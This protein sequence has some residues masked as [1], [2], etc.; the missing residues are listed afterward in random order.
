MSSLHEITS[1]TLRK[2]QLRCIVKEN[3]GKPITQLSFN[4][5]DMRARNVLATTASD[6]VTIY[7]N[8]HSHDGSD[9]RYLDMMS[10]FVNEKSEHTEGGLLNTITWVKSENVEDED[11]YLVAAGTG[12]KFSV[13]VI[14]QANS[15]VCEMLSGHHTSQVL[16]VASWKGHDGYFI[17]CSANELFVWRISKGGTCVKVAEK[18]LVNVTAA[19]TLEKSST[20]NI[21]GFAIANNKGSI[22]VFRLSLLSFDLL[23]V[24][25]R[26]IFISKNKRKTQIDCV[27]F[28]DSSR[29]VVNSRA[30]EIAICNL[31]D[32][33]EDLYRKFTIPSCEKQPIASR[34]GLS[35][36]N[37]FLACGT[38]NGNVIIFDI[39]QNERVHTL[40]F[41][42]CT[43]GV[44]DV[45]FSYDGKQILF[46]TGPIIWR[47]DFCS[48]ENKENLTNLKDGKDEIAEDM[49]AQKKQKTKK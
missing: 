31:E 28:I 14:S 12:D 38:A 2:L 35:P 25:E 5:H 21:L 34:F 41:K 18:K 1:S 49:P 39:E 47:W 27:A 13:L 40:I 46:S 20:D 44:S 37:K 29:I 3:H 4:S 16:D 9:G 7:D 48:E 19:A 26:Q 30:G 33:N 24:C 10:H 36:C 17:S 43:D 32:E 42:R 23:L 45:T 8:T 22:Q 15:A 6:Q 11:A